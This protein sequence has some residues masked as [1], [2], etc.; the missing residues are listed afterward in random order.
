MFLTAP[1]TK[2]FTLEE[3]DDVFD[4]GLP[5]WRKLDKR[6]RLDELEHQIIDGQ[7][8]VAAPGLVGGATTKTTEKV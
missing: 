8:K 5:A 7:L 1:E 2:G 4:S 3:M 6:S